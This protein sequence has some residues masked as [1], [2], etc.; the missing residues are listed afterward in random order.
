MLGLRSIKPDPKD[1]LAVLEDF[2]LFCLGKKHMSPERFME[3]NIE[4]SVSAV[5]SIGRHRYQHSADGR[6]LLW[7]GPDEREHDL[8]PVD[9]VNVL[10]NYPGFNRSRT[11]SLGHDQ[12]AENEVIDVPALRRQITVVKMK[13]GSTGVAPNYKMALRNAALKMHL[14]HQFNRH[15]L[16]HAIDNASLRG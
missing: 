6:H 16:A 9:E 1:V 15:N 8:G 7:T 4:L 11:L 12:V 13:D 10:R 5:H 2:E 3:L 14:K